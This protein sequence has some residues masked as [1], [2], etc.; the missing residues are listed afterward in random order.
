[1]PVVNGI[2]VYFQFLYW[3]EKH[4]YKVDYTEIVARPQ[5]QHAVSLTLCYS[6][7][8]FAAVSTGSPAQR[9]APHV[10]HEKEKYRRY[11]ASREMFIFMRVGRPSPLRIKRGL[12][13]CTIMQYVSTAAESKSD[14]HHVSDG[15]DLRP[16]S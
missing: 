14:Q 4:T 10:V 13:K 3:C 11:V 8:C 16:I 5:I 6:P 12:H 7:V 2:Y 15:V 1:M 9:K